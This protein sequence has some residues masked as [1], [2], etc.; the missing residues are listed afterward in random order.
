MFNITDKDN[1][2][3]ASGFSTHQDAEDYLLT[4]LGDLYAKERDTYHIEV[5]DE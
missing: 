2:Q 3:V 5:E 1:R 4:M